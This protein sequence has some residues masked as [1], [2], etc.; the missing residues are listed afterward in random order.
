MASAMRA[1]TSLVT[2]LFSATRWIM[3]RICQRARPSPSSFQRTSIKMARNSLTSPGLGRNRQAMGARRR[4]ITLTRWLTP[5][6][7]LCGAGGVLVAQEPTQLPAVIIRGARGPVTVSG[8]VRD[9]FG[10]P[11]EGVE[12]LI[13]GLQ[14]RLYSAADGTFHLD[15]LPSGTFD[16][17]ARKIGYFPKIEK[18][19]KTGGAGG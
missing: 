14:R 1:A 12:I 13:P 10:N 9:K 8:T 11:I 6:M 7:M 4:R 16:V 17:W 5:V 3:P 2:S 19:V 15:S 18:S